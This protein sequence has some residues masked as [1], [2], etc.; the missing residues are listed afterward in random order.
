MARKRLAEFLREEAQK[1]LDIAPVPEGKTTSKTE[2]TTSRKQKQ[3]ATTASESTSGTNRKPP[4]NQTGAQP[5]EK[6]LATQKRQTT[7]TRQSK[8]NLKA[9]QLPL[10]EPVKQ[11]SQTARKTRTN[12]T[13][14]T[15]AK[16]E[17]AMAPTKAPAAPAH[18][19]VSAA[20][21]HL[22]TTVAEL[23]TALQEAKVREE[24]LQH[25]VKSLQTD[26]TAAQK[27][28]GQLQKEQNHAVQTKTE[29]EEAR[30]VILQLSEL[31]AA[32]NEQLKAAKTVPAKTVPAKTVNQPVPSSLQAP[33]K[34]PAH[35]TSR[36]ITPEMHS[37]VELR[38][39]LQHPTAPG[40]PPNT[41]MTN[42]EIGW[43][44]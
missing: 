12:Q 23:K 2:K 17:Q 34:F 6:G 8:A 40:A 3:T 25:Q 16:G 44:D 38:R 4:T 37:Q 1:S 18:D 27:T 22:E 24:V 21:A 42:E 19:E 32:L 28:L 11:P 41:A 35:D 5:T 31:N 26:L 33:A 13:K 7:Q 10:Q 29:L 15:G 9:E 36:M 14:Q 39:M 43:V 20:Q 30:K